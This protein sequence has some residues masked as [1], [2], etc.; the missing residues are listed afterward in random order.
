MI[1]VKKNNLSRREEAKLRKCG[2]SCKDGKFLNITSAGS[3]MECNLP[4]R[5]KRPNCPFPKRLN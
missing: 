1:V 3:K 5:G 4:V 2:H